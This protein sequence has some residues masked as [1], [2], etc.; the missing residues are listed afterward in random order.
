MQKVW[1]GNEKVRVFA[2]LPDWFRISTPLG[3]YNP[4]WAVL[5]EDDGQNKL[6][7]VVETKGNIEIG[8]L[9]GNELDKIRCGRKHFEAL[10]EDIT[11]KAA[12][13][14]E[15]FAESV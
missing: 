4:D 5:I 11:F 9:R 2:K 10:G 3:A 14:Y 15:S 8:A 7:F 13:G 6:Y 12:D 1:T